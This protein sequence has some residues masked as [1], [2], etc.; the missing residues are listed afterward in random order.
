LGEGLRT[1]VVDAGGVAWGSV[2]VLAVWAV[3]GLTLAARFFR[4]E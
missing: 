4:W 1:A 2:S 3:A